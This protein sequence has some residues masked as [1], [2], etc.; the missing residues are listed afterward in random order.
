M[1]EWW[2]HSCYFGTGVISCQDGSEVTLSFVGL[3]LAIASVRPDPADEIEYLS[4]RRCYPSNGQ[5]HHS[6][7]PIGLRR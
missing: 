5:T 4:A 1:E 2:L 6:A 3:L 7:N